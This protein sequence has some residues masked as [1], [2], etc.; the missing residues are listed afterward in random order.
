MVVG[1]VMALANGAVLPAMVIV[2]GDMTDSFVG[3]ASLPPNITLPPS[4][5]QLRDIL[6]NR[7]NK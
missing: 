7:N 3:D 5:S 4:E 1:T 2:F 6:F